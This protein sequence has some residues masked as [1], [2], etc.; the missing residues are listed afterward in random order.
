MNWWRWCSWMW[1]GEARNSSS[2]HSFDSIIFS[3]TK[4][5]LACV[6]VF[7]QKRKRI[8]S[9]IILTV[10]RCTRSRW[11]W[12]RSACVFCSFV[13]FSSFVSNRS[14][15]CVR[16]WAS[17]SESENLAKTNILTPLGMIEMGFR[18]DACKQVHFQRV[19][20]VS[21]CGCGWLADWHTRHNIR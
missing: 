4:W 7:A 20:C 8:Y 13:L 9:T 21:V 2:S 14:R 15:M 19:S 11:R 1:S 16:V 17:A 12:W 5:I 10:S 6:S 3:C 18:R